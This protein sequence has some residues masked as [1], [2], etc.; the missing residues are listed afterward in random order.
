METVE[1]KCE[2]K[3]NGKIYPCH[4]S[5]AMDLIGGKWKSVILYYLKDGAKRFNEIK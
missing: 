2:I 5:M 4:I 1:N 3:M